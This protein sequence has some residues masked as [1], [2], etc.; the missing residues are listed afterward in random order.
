MTNT[1]CFCCADEFAERQGLCLLCWGQRQTSDGK[2][3][4]ENIVDIDKKICNAWVGPFCP[5]KF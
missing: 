4:F 3:K 2:M 1:K 5:E